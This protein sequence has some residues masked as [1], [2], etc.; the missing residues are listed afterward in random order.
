MTEISLT[1]VGALAFALLTLF[2]VMLWAIDALRKKVKELHDSSP[3]EVIRRTLA[4]AFE[5]GKAASDHIQPS[6]RD[7]SHDWSPAYKACRNCNMP[8]AEFL[9]SFA[10]CPSEVDEDRLRAALTVE[11]DSWKTHEDLPGLEE[12]A[13]DF[14]RDTALRNGLHHWQGYKNIITGQPAPGYPIC[15]ICLTNQG[16]VISMDRCPGF[17]GENKDR[18][19]RGARR[20][21][22]ESRHYFMWR[23]GEEDETDWVLACVFCE[24]INT[25][26]RGGSCPSDPWD[27]AIAGV[28]AAGAPDPRVGTEAAR[29]RMFCPRGDGRDLEVHQIFVRESTAARREN[30]HY[31][32]VW[33]FASSRAILLCVFCK[34]DYRSTLN[35]KGRCPGPGNSALS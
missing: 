26:G 32:S 33:S 13:S 1:L 28:V 10:V 7:S 5:K 21:R 24:V 6:D 9:E 20:A 17:D 2:L 30:R 16:R 35:G 11:D 18:L 19:E 29:R 23:K 12:T 25:E 34:V 27:Q 8:R 31:F 4:E 15:T 14:G 22:A 3:A